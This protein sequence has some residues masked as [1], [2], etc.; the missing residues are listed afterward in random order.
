VSTSSASGWNQLLSNTY[1][2]GTTTA[3]ALDGIMSNYRV[4]AHAIRIRLEIPQN[5]ATGRL[6]VAR[7]PR[8][9]SDPNARLLFAK[10]YGFD[11][12]TSAY[13]PITT[14]P[15]NPVA[16]SP[17]LL[18]TPES[19]E[20]S[21]IDLMGNDIVVINAPN[22]YDAFKFCD[23]AQSVII[24]TGLEE[25]D[26]TITSNTTGTVQSV[27]RVDNYPGWDDIYL[28]FDGLPATGV[29]VANI[30]YILHLEGSPNISSAST[31][32]AVPS[33]PPAAPEAF[34]GF[35]A[36]Q[37]FVS[38]TAKI[39]FTDAPTAYGNATGGRNLLRDVSSGVALASRRGLRQRQLL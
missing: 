19:Q 16:N 6:I 35:D 17:F 25:S 8:S 1:F 34:M 18:E 33:H 29:P 22:S 37:R 23:I 11:Y 36:I 27:G 28:Y 13:A 39:V 10:T 15:C 7:A 3:S 2:W 24:G 20:F 26:D 12:Q 14:Y 21:M 4:V 38:S 31:I 5:L 9:R 32:T 30:E